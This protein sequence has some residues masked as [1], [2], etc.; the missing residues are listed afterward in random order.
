MEAN[1]LQQT[2]ILVWS[3]IVCSQSTD[4]VNLKHHIG[5]STNGVSPTLASKSANYSMTGIWECD[6]TDE[7]I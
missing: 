2:I 3:M 5:S 7:E 6:T 4:A 1:T